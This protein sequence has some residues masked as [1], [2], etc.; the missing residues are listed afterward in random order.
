MG[1]LIATELPNKPFL[2]WQ[3]WDGED[4]PLVIDE[5]DMP[6]NQFGVSPLKIVNGQLEE[7][8]ESEMAAYEAEYLA[9]QPAYEYRAKVNGLDTAVFTFSG[10]DYPMHQSARLFYSCMERA[11]SNYKVM[12]AQGVIR[13]IL[14][15]D[16]EAFLTAY[17]NELKLQTQP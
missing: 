1:K 4:T 14:E 10:N 3:T 12:D 2:F 5:E 11:A 17:Y 8:S 15:T 6:Q 13:D 9:E 7:R 16:N